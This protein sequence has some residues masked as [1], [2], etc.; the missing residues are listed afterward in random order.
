MSFGKILL[1]VIGQNVLCEWTYCN[2][3][4]YRPVTEHP[5]FH[6]STSAAYDDDHRPEYVAPRKMSAPY[7]SPPVPVADVEDR[8]CG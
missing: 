7:S 4:Y 6:T 1:P 3:P 8:D 5:S 2:V